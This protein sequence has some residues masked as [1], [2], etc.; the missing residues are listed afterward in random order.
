VVPA[1]DMTPLEQAAAAL[2][3]A[4]E[5]Y[6]SARAASA[7]QPTPAEVSEVNAALMGV[8]R[9]FL[10]KGGLPGRPHYANELYSPGR[11]WDTVP[12]PAVG[13]AML[14]G[15]WDDAKAQLPLA[16]AT[17]QAIAAAIDRATAALPHAAATR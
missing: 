15:Q 11:L 7:S 9:S 16:A 14:D 10:R 6:A 8:E 3:A 5:R 12:V 2:R 1:I 4:A 17:I 13:D